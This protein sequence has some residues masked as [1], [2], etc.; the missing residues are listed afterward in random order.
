MKSLIKAIGTALLLAALL[1]AVVSGQENYNN[2][3]AG[4]S[5]VIKVLNAPLA[6]S[7]S[8]LTNK[9]MA[10]LSI[11][12][13]GDIVSAEAMSNR[14]PPFPRDLYSID[15]MVNWGAE[16]GKRYL[17]IVNVES[18]GLRRKRTFN[19]P[20]IMQKYEN[21]GEI[22]GELRVVDVSRKKVVLAEAF[23]FEKEAKRIV[24]A[25]IDDD[26]N[27]AD[28]HISA[29]EK[30]RFFSEMES[31]FV[32]ELAGKIRNATVLR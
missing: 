23:K 5:A 29:P 2:H 31:E 25:A 11:N 18:E 6:W 14:M 28:L 13:N 30:I 19:I 9:L 17:V 3:S 4:R 24:Q 22:L 26:I 1:I 21:V 12:G 10:E 32:K 8:Q 15:S 7:E 16:S 20:L 27:D